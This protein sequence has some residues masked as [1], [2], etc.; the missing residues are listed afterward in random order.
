MIHRLLT[1]WRLSLLLL[2]LIPV[3]TPLQAQETDADFQLKADRL[4]KIVLLRP[5]AGTALD[6]L[7]R[8][9]QDAGTE[10]L[11][12]ERVRAHLDENPDD[13]VLLEVMQRFA[14]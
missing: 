9:Y 2:A 8:H 14:Q 7:I 13:D 12:I 3:A 4:A 1:H 5:R 10:Q 11:L 6:L